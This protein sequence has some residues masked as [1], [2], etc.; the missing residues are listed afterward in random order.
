MKKDILFISAIGYLIAFD[1]KI[2]TNKMYLVPV[3]IL[4]IIMF[5]YIPFTTDDKKEKRKNK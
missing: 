1:E 5:I 4:L 3:F 2:D